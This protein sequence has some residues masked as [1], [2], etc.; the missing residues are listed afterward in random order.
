MDHKKRSR[1]SWLISGILLLNLSCADQEKPEVVSPAPTSKTEIDTETTT[2]TI[3]ATTVRVDLN[4]R[5]P[6]LK[7]S[8]YGL[9]QDLVKA[10]P[11][12]GVIPYELNATSFV[13][14]AV[15]RGFLWVPPSTAATFH[16][17]STLEFPVGTVFVQN[18]H[19]PRKADDPTAGE[20]LVET[21]LLIHGNSGWIGVPYLWNED[22]TDADR[23]VIGARTDVTVL[24]QDGSELTFPYITP[25]MNQCKQCHV[26]EHEMKPIGVTA[27]NLNRTIEF[28]GKSG[29]QLEHWH[30]IGVLSETPENLAEAFADLRDQTSGNVDQ[31]ARTWLNANCAHC[32]NPHGPAIVSG[33]DLSF[34]QKQPVRFGVYKPPVAAGRG[35]KGLRFSILPNRPD[36]SFLLHRISSTELGVMM[37]PLGRSTTDPVGIALVRE[38]ITEMPEDKALA[39][40]A[41]NPMRAYRDA[42]LPGNAERGKTIFHEVQKCITC[43]RV[44]NEGG[45]VGPNLS[46]VGKRTTREYLLESV[47]VPSE[48]IVKGFET[49]IIITKDGRVVTGVIQ[50]EDEYEIAIAD[51]RSSTKIQKSEIDEREESTVSTM[52]TLANLLT[53]EDVRDVVSYLVTL[54]TPPEK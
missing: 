48:K 42:I 47:V 4:A 39:E 11:S 27:R 3:P 32:H 54:Q 16:K 28:D 10:V 31:R 46:D 35:S 25:N 41:L 9:F 40:A 36:E 2:A 53:V 17:D 49:E 20:R 26:N 12:P 44:G 45:K 33:L 22:G 52:P 30:S 23:V 51:A 24:Q 18:I 37:P 38:W 43:H 1:F 50:S 15:Q 21:R 29:N 19:F 14:H 8:E 7:L 5:R 6:A 13:D 34:D